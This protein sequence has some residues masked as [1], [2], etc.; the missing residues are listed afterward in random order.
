MREDKVL[1]IYFIVCEEGSVRKSLKFG[2]RLTRMLL[3]RIFFK[4]SECKC[5]IRSD[6]NTIDVKNN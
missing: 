6:W 2:L 5:N 1:N 3:S 4:F